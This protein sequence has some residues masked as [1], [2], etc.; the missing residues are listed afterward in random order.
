[1]SSVGTVTAVL[2]SLSPQSWYSSNRAG[3]A[4]ADNGVLKLEVNK[5]PEKTLGERLRPIITSFVE[6]DLKYEPR[7]AR[8]NTA[9]W[10]AAD[11][12]ANQTGVLREPGSRSAKIFQT[13]VMYAACCVPRH[14]VEVQV[15]VAMYSWLG[16]LLDD[17]AAEHEDEFARFGARWAGGERHPLP[18]LQAWADLLRLT[19]KYW[20]AAPANFIV[21]ASLNFLNSN[22]LQTGAAFRGIAAAAAANGSNGNSNNS[23]RSWAR[24][25]REEDGGGDAVAYFTFPKSMYPNQEEYLECIPDLARYINLANDVLS[26]YKEEIAGENDNFISQMAMYEDKDKLA[27][28]ED[29]VDD[30]AQAVA[31]IRATIRGKEPYASAVEDH[32]LGYV[33]FHKLSPRYRLSEVGLGEETF[34]VAP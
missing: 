12:Y 24:Y 17:S 30:V 32:I 11:E 28:V 15:Y 31:R 13:G 2:Q 22:L 16:L 25:V 5:T 7:P 9:L 29:L 19:Y 33:A 8:D 27:V 21:T 26:F 20:D 1:M 14:P 18:L 3:N 10:K 23:G 4:L 6:D 34:K